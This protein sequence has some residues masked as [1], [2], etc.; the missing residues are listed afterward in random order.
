MKQDLAALCTPGCPELAP[1]VAGL[2]RAD[3]S[4]AVRHA[5]VHHL[6][7]PTLPAVELAGAA[8]ATL[9]DVRAAYRLLRGN[10]A[11]ATLTAS[12][13]YPHRLKHRLAVKTTAEWAAEPERLARLLAGEPVLA[14]TV[15][16]HP[17]KGTC[18]YRCAMCLWSDK[19][20]LT[21]ATRGLTARGLLSTQQWL[22]TIEE[23]HAHGVQTLVI[24]GGGEALLNPDLPAILCRARNLGLRT[25]LYTTG[26]NLRRAA[27]DLWE[28]IARTYRVRLSIH[29]PIQATYAQITG[30]PT[31]LHA[32]R[33]VSEHAQRLLDLR[34]RISSPLR[35]GIGFVLMPV[36]HDEIL[37]MV[38]FAAELG[39]DFLDIRKDEVNVTDDLTADQ[40]AAV[41]RQL[42]DLRGRARRGAYGGLVVD[43]SDELVSLANDSPVLRRRTR[44]CLAKYAR[45]T[46]SPFGILAPCDL[47]AEPRFADSQFNLAL[48][49]QPVED[50]LDAIGRT[51]VPDACAQCMPSSR[52]TNAVYAKLLGDVRDGLQLCDQPFHDPAT[53]TD[54]HALSRI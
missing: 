52:T 50:M 42:I 6:A 9:N 28:E 35:L 47:K 24:S 3:A 54:E 8:S 16:I 46:I 17:S 33:R 22:D 30:L 5:A 1:V 34:N 26:Y 23:L 53:T 32:L 31:G 48:M 43:L 38:D 15:E 45:P 11:V 25:Q 4:S 36:N 2:Q 18:T 7:D 39:V 21:Y 13:F 27:P 41:R 20:T 51:F 49:P 44:E 40:R 12:M 29:S 14:T 19:T 10:R 37:T